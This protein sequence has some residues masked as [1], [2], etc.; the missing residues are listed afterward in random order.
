MCVIVA[1]YF[2]GIGWAGAKNRDRR[3]IPTLDFI[4]E[5]VGD[6][7]RCLMH[8]QVTGYKEGINSRGVSILNTS[9]DVLEDEPEVQSG[10][11]NVSPDGT[12]IAQ[13]LAEKT[14]QDAVRVLINGRLVG[15]TIVFD[16]DTLFLIEASDQDGTQRYRYVVK[17]IAPDK[18]ICRTNHGL[19]LE[20][21][22][23][24]RRADDPQQTRDRISSESRWLQ[25]NEVVQ[26]AQQ[27]EDLVNG[28][29]QMLVNH[30]QLNIMRTST[31]PNQF[32]TTSQQL[33]VPAERTLYCRPVSSNLQ[34]DFW[35]LNKPN[36]DT[37]VEILSNRELWNT[38][39]KPQ[40]FDSL[41]L[42]D[43]KK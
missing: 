30:P 13:A 24:Q 21:A 18:T 43:V 29:C 4:I 20:W 9:L 27:P 7:E 32:R 10:S 8:D 25:A 26:A 2:P 31:E 39:K 38:A 17:E 15:C 23:F 41:K 34:F 12:L 5:N 19:W 22:S 11:A 16:K 42:K 6:V 14:P 28:M 35:K 36:R 37:W 1:K 40:P 3:Y 33:C